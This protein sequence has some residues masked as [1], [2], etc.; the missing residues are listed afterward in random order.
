MMTADPIP[1]G[2]VA[3]VLAAH[4]SE[5]SERDVAELLDRA[6]DAANTDAPLTAAEE[7]FFRDNAGVTLEKPHTVRM[8]RVLEQALEA[9]AFSVE[10][11]STAEAARHCKISES[12]MRH[13]IAA[14]EVCVLP[15]DGRSR[16]L[17]LWQFTKNGTVPHLRDVLAALPDEMP[18]AV[19]EAFM[20]E[21]TEDLQMGG[22]PVSVAEWLTAGGALGP[23]LELTASENASR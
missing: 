21:P 1:A 18:A 9:H 4:H 14:R 19:V 16:R 5:L 7:A 6:L 8:Q 3:K 15:A 23:V 2:P 11:I 10:S 22:K 12:R 17:P 13:R 20:T